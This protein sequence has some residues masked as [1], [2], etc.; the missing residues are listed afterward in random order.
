MT[1]R[2]VSA[3]PITP[4]G[5]EIRPPDIAPHADGN[6]G[7]PYVHRFRAPAPGPHVLV[8]AIVHG[9][10][11]CGAIVLDHALRTGL[12]PRRGTLTLAFCN[13]EAYR[14][15][16]PQQP[17]RARF[18]DEDFN[19]LWSDAILDGPL[20]TPG[21]SS[22]LR[23]AREIR[24]FVRA[25][26]LLLDLHSMQSPAAALTLSGPLERGR[27]L[28]RAV[29]V[30]A[31]VVADPGHASGPRMRDYGGF[32]DPNGT[33]NALLVECGQHWRAASVETAFQV[34]YAFL[35]TAGILDAA[36]I[37]GQVPTR[38]PVQRFYDVTDVITVRT[39]AFRFVRPLATHDVVPVAGT[40]IAV[41]GDIPIATPYDDC[42]IVMPSQR[43]IR[44]ATAVRLAREIVL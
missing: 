32:A 14:R 6:A 19:R 11:P 43:P 15:F 22:E 37:A 3:G 10:E 28:A 25:A 7:V 44:G 1:D 38:P 39:D 2:D 8:T 20:N 21:T 40:E 41:D 18:V 9:N 33:R 24:P 36:D 13:V 42:L 34:F 17:A 29:G 5:M 30:P 16:D 35:R 23:R 26:D 12:R 27:D 31:V 4:R